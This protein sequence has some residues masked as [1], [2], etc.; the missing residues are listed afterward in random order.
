M[1]ILLHDVEYDVLYMKYIY[2]KY[3]FPFSLF[4]IRCII[5]SFGNSMSLCL[6]LIHVS[7]HY[8]IFP[9]TCTCVATYK[10]K[11]CNYVI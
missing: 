10:K 8:H 3:V 1:L 2:M 9:F 4:F 5:A 6:I 7:L 11:V